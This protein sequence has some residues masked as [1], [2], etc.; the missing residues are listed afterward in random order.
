MTDIDKL[1]S[2]IEKARRVKQNTPGKEAGTSGT[3]IFGGFIDS[4]EKNPSLTGTNR[5]RTA[6]D[7]LA[8]ISVV[9][10]SVRYFLNLLANPKWNVVPADDTAEAKAAAE[11]VEEVMA[12]LPDSWTRIVRR[13]GMYKFHGFSLQEWTAK[14]REDGRTGFK[15]LQSRP[16]HTIE[17]W[18]TDDEDNEI[19]G[20]VQ[21][22][23][24]TGA[25]LPID[26]WKLI[27]LVDD[28]LTDSPEGM[29]W[30]RHL[31]EPCARLQE[32]LTLEKVGF[33]RDLAGVPVGRAP[34][35]ALNRAVKAGAISR[36]DADRMIQG[37]KDFV[38][39]EIK[40]NN[41]GMVLDSQH[42]EDQ[43]SDGA[44]ASGVAQWG[45]ELLTGDAG[46]IAQLGEAIKRISFEIGLIIGTE[47]MFTGSDG[48]GS[49]ALSQDKSSN[50]YLNINSTLDE[51]TEVFTKDFIGSLWRLNGLDD[52]LRPKF[53]HEDVS[54][55]DVE[56]IAVVLRDMAAAGAILAPDDPAIDDVRELMG[57]PRQEV[58]TVI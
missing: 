2:N 42:F 14:R 30:F 1:N 11:F 38:K 27:Y 4:G 15:S 37:L 54:F 28:T 48:K 26:L 12:D 35:T 40:K 9:A 16:Q 58:P 53:T 13:S 5:Y 23:P 21:R 36:Q 25:E 51:M 34:I 56:Q 3:A 20:V 22:S 49:L 41:T 52:K 19:L 44:K 46:S 29:G 8:N 33:E 17:R 45:I 31:A 6:S 43:T 55:K 7:I 18:V 50:L 10:A 24:Q 57:V 32:Y 39:M 47:N